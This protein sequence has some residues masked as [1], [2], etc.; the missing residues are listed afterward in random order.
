MGCGTSRFGV[1]DNVTP[2]DSSTDGLST[3]QEEQLFFSSDPTVSDRQICVDVSQPR[4]QV[5]SYPREAPSPPS[6]Q[7]QHATAAPSS[8]ILPRQSSSPLAALAKGVNDESPLNSSSP[9]GRGACSDRCTT[10]FTPR[11]RETQGRSSAEASPRSVGTRSSSSA[12]S[13]PRTGETRGIFFNSVPQGVEKQS[14]SSSTSSSPRVGGAEA[15][16]SDPPQIRG[17]AQR[18]A[19]T[20]LS[21]S[22][23]M[24]NRAI[25]EGQA[26]CFSWEGRPKQNRPSSSKGQASQMTTA[27][28]RAEPSPLPQRRQATPSANCP[29]TC[30]EVEQPL[31]DGYTSDVDPSIVRRER[32]VRYR[33]VADTSA[34]N[35]PARGT[36]PRTPRQEPPPRGRPQVLPR[37]SSSSSQ[38][39]GH[40]SSSR[41]IRNAATKNS[42][43]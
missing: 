32:I 6:L 14:N 37:S 9:S 12:K 16:S 7:A 29:R 41:H 2:S 13:S 26:S 30:F 18:L 31:F 17:L 11:G 28:T 4:Q 3:V 10:Y 43:H 24:E 5:S 34:H 33:P 36:G 27:M 21:D 42:V 22:R 25:Q 39:S 40:P 20:D 38:D 19:Q 1:V 35:S 15:G 8:Q 23:Q